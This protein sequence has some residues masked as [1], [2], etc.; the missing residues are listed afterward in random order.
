MMFTIL[1]VVVVV[2]AVM[3]KARPAALGQLE[4]TTT[5]FGLSEVELGVDVGGVEEDA[6]RGGGHI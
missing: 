3:A 1:V 2:V 4:Y 5:E 6:G